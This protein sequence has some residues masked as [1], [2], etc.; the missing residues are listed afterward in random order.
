MTAVIQIVFENVKQT[1]GLVTGVKNNRTKPSSVL[2]TKFFEKISSAT[3]PCSYL[4]VMNV[5]FSSRNVCCCQYCP[6]TWRWRWKTILYLPWKVS[7][8]K[9]TSR[10]TKTSGESHPYSICLMV[11]YCF[12]A[13]SSGL[14]NKYVMKQG[15]NKQKQRLNH[16]FSF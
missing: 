6:N 3:T 15:K 4:Q 10:S 14:M 2:K 16:L 11:F 9:F 8:I 7:S 5:P 13:A 1:V 12:D